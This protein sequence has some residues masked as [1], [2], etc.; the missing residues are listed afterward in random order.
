MMTPIHQ[1]ISNQ[2]HIP[3]ALHHP[4][5]TIIVIITAQKKRANGGMATTLRFFEWMA[6]RPTTN[7]ETPEWGHQF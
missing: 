4:P 3:A 1:A 2:W 7:V 5:I 6:G